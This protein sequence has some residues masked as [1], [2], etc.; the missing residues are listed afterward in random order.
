MILFVVGTAMVPAAG[1]EPPSGGGTAEHGAERKPGK[2][3]A[4]FDVR[5]G[6][7]VT[8]ER[9][10][11][12]AEEHAPRMEVARARKALGEAAIAGAQP[13]LPANPILEMEAGPRRRADGRGFD[14]EATLTQPIQIAG[15]RRMDRRAGRRTADRWASELRKARWE[16]HTRVHAAYLRVQLARAHVQIAA[17]MHAFQQGLIHITRKRVEAGE[18]APLD[19]RLVEGEAAR[20]H[21]RGMRAA[22]RYRSARL[23][24][25]EVAGWPVGRPPEAEGRFR[26][27]VREAPPADRLVELA[28]AEHPALRLR[29]ARVAQT[30]AEAEAA[31]RAAWPNP[32]IGLKVG[33]VEPGEQP[34]RLVRGILRVPLPLWRRNQGTRAETSAHR[35]IARAE[36]RRVRSVLRPRIVRAARAL[37]ASAARVRMYSERVSPKLERTLEMLQRAYEVGEV[38][39]VEVSVRRERLLRAQHDAFETYRAYADAFAA[40]E[41]AVGTD[42]WQS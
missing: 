5:A 1:A 22:Q 24:L 25:A 7:R 3:E 26:D 27:S 36:R 13:L 29:D 8:L 11:A 18:I 15:E 21:E 4:P 17:A 33:R 35:E 20:V 12:W 37:D 19:L 14:V 39:V 34:A 40:L 41:R 28:Y 42:P 6:E 10:L 30:R 23:R 31:D 38:G 9:M 2:D 16:T 32:V